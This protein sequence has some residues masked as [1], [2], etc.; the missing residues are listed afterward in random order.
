ML[1]L[2][3]R[4]KIDI[5]HGHRNNTSASKQHLNIETTH[6]H[7]NNFPISKKNMSTLIIFNPSKVEQP[8]R[9]M[10]LQEQ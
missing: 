7:L 3:F 9:D 6:R 2:L 10:E 1:I 5:K 8:L 4:D